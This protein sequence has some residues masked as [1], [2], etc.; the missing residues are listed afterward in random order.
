MKEFKLFINGQWKESASGNVVEDINP[1][2][3]QAFAKIHQPSDN[4]V[5]AAVAAAVA[6]GKEWES[7]PNI[8]PAS[9]PGI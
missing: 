8:T 5:D 9:Q 3:G 6:A 7:T 2:T 1:A 4:D